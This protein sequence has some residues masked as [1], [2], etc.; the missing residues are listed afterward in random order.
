MRLIFLVLT[1]VVLGAGAGLVS[2]PTVNAHS[3]GGGGAVELLQS[4]SSCPSSLESL[5]AA[6]QGSCSDL[7]P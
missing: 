7:R 5:A 1:L 6:S 4:A 2:V 3:G